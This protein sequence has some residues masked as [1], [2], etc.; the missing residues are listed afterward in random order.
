MA[1]EKLQD[2]YPISDKDMVQ[3]A[4]Q[5]HETKEVRDYKFPT[6]VIDLPSKGLIYQPE[7]D[8]WAV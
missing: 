7:R 2:E 3:K 8:Q 5:Q 1:K 6:E 4:I